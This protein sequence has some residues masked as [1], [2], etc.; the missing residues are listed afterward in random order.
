[1]GKKK[2]TK[3][4]SASKLG[5]GSKYVQMEIPQKLKMI[6]GWA[7]H[8][9]TLAEIAE[10]LKISEATLYRWKGMHE[11]FRN[12]LR[13]GQIEANGEILNSAFRQAT[14]YK[15]RVSELIKRRVPVFVV[16]EETEKEELLM[17]NKGHAV[18][19]EVA[20]VHEYDKY[21]PPDARM[22]MFMLANRL[23]DK[24]QVK[25]LSDEATG[26][27]IVQHCVPETEDV[28]DAEGV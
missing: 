15:E 2:T 17:D 25:V 23:K 24:Y 14:G 4:G 5:R 28:K 8:G 12:A 3:K 9:S 21:F 11:E 1:M 16:N 7:R 6:E 19:Q 10:M 18:M 13:A 20:E 27:I 26:N 22:T